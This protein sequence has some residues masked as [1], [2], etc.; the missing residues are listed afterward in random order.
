MTAVFYCL[1]QPAGHAA[2]EIIDVISVSAVFDQKV[3]VAFMG[4]G[5]WQLF[6]NTTIATGKN[7]VKFLAALPT[8]D[9]DEFLVERESLYRQN[10]FDRFH[11]S[12]NAA[13]DSFLNHVKIKDR[14]VIRERMR[15]FDVIVTD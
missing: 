10:L 3:A 7:T 8:F 11:E 4:D 12:R 13:K 1:S 15:A 6:D 2:N 14:S 5:V 9:V